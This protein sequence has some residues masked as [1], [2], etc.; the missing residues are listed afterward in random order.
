MKTIFKTW[1]KATY[2][3]GRFLLLDEKSNRAT[4]IYFPT[5]FTAFGPAIRSGNWQRCT[6]INTPDYVIEHFFD[7]IG[8]EKHH[9]MGMMWEFCKQLENITWEYFKNNKNEVL[10]LVNLANNELNKLQTL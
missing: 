1:K 7:G 8:H 4:P 5:V 10:S 6:S 2:F 9:T 3:E